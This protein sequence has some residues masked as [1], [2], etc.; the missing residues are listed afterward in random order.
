METLCEAYRMAKEDG[1]APGIDG[2]TFETIEESGVEGFLRQIREELRLPETHEMRALP[3]RCRTLPVWK[4]GRVRTIP[5][6]TWVKV[7]IDT[8]TG[9]AGHE[10]RRD[11]P[12]LQRQGHTAGP[13]AGRQVAAIATIEVTF[14]L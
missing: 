1:G 7:A 3:P 8:W 5:M 9:P 12:V 13:A 14:R 4:H 11:D 10:R 6:P 2:V